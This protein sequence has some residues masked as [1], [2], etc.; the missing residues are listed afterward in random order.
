MGNILGSWSGMRKYLEKEML[1]ECLQGRVRYECTT[2]AG[3]DGCHIFRVFVDDEVKKRFSWETVNS[4]FIENEKYP[5]GK[6]LKSPIT[7]NEY[8]K[9]FHYTLFSIPVNERDEYTD[10]E[11][12]EALAEYRQHNIKDSIISDNP[13]VQ[14]FAILDKRIG[15]RTLNRI[16]NTVSDKSE[17]LQF[18]YELRLKGEGLI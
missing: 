17:W 15:K 6:E 7:K 13:V 16:K 5:N 10:N 8:W 1:A 18:F 3:M 11:F 9:D 12:C 2:Y 14:M 4:Y